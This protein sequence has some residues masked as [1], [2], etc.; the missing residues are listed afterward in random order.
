MFILYMVIA[1]GLFG[2]MLM[3]LSERTREFGVLISIGMKRFKLASI[4]WMEM[5][6]IS[7]V[8]VF[9]GIAIAYPICQYFYSNPIQ[10]GDDQA[11]MMAD[12]GMEAMLQFSIDPSIFLTQAVIIFS[13]SS[14]LALFSFR[15]LFKLNPQEAMRA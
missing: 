9:L 10:F 5:I 2:T 3:M 11:E 7:I 15:K 13:I 14:V 12:Y 1:F 8:G 6:M 4:V